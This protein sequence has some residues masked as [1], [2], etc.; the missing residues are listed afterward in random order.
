M[1]D[2]ATMTLVTIV[3]EAELE[4]RIARDILAAGAKG[5]TSSMARGE[6]AHHR[7]ASDIEGGNVRI[8][9]VVAEPVAD[10]IMAMLADRYFPNYATVAWLSSVRVVRADEFS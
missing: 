7:H 1:G 8:E 4:S 2:Y 6:G 5:F 3:T 9:T 10:A